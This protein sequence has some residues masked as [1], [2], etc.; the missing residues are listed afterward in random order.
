[1]AAGDIDGDTTDDLIIG[2]Y[3]AA[4]AGGA[5]AGETY[6]IY[7]GP[8][9]PATIDLDSASAGLTVFGDDA[10][11]FSGFSVAA[12]DIDGDTTDDLIIGAL[13]ADPAGGSAAG[14]TYVI[15]GE[16]PAPPVGGIAQYPAIAESAVR[17]SDSPASGSGSSA[18]SYALLAALAA[19]AAATLAAGGWYARRRWVR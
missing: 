16:L 14:E 15:Y 6:V 11:D 1:M 19:V 17:E 13:F 18:R 12:G 2:A 10:G 8:G 4:P 5:E 7:G 3:F 9:L